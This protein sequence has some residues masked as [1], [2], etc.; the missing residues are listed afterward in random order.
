MV[1][2]PG[3]TME[4]IEGMISLVKTIRG[5]T[6]KGYIRLSVS[7]F[8]PKPFTPFQWHPMEPLKSVKEKLR[9]IKK[10]LVLEKV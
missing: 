7:T 5:N 10:G 8:V 4:D 2:L 9:R 6:R 3:E 1:G